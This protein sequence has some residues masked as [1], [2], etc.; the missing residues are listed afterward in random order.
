METSEYLTEEIKEII[1]Q[2]DHQMK[3]T[4]KLHNQS[5]TI[6]NLY[7]DT[8]ND[9]QKYQKY[10]KQ[11]LKKKKKNQEILKQQ[12]RREEEFIRDYT[13]LNLDF[14]Q[15]ITKIKK[16]IKSTRK[17]RDEIYEEKGIILE[18]VVANELHDQMLQYLGTVDLKTIKPSFFNDFQIEIFEKAQTLSKDF[19]KKFMENAHLSFR[20]TKQTFYVTLDRLKYFYSKQLYTPGER[21]ETVQSILSEVKLGEETR[22]ILENFGQMFALWSWIIIALEDRPT[23]TESNDESHLILKGFTNKKDILAQ[24]QKILN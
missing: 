21:L 12:K 1:K 24:E 5:E 15:I 20:T 23:L 10:K 16:D 18:Y 19:T 13:Q 17:R 6:R 22:T 3:E 4:E 7:K 2:N 14:T 8:Q 11:N 9:T